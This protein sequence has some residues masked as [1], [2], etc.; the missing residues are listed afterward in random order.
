MFWKASCSLEEKVILINSEINLRMRYLTVRRLHTRRHHIALQS[1]ASQDRRLSDKNNRHKLS[2][3]VTCLRVT[4]HANGANLSSRSAVLPPIGQELEWFISSSL[5]LNVVRGTVTLGTF[6]QEKNAF[7]TLLQT[8]CEL[9]ERRS[10]PQLNDGHDW[11]QE[12]R[13]RER[14]VVGGCL[15]CAWARQLVRRTAWHNTKWTKDDELSRVDQLLDDA[16]RMRDE[17]HREAGGSLSH[18]PTSI[19]ND[20]WWITHTCL[21]R[22]LVACLPHAQPRRRLSGWFRMAV[23]KRNSSEAA[24]VGRSVWHNWMAAARS[25]G[26]RHPTKNMFESGRKRCCENGGMVPMCSILYGASVSPVIKNSSALLRK[27]STMAT[28]F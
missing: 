9:Y 20:V 11:C 2:G 19:R 12:G 27:P 15:V 6:V 7:E 22:T 8:W 28:L 16:I 23:G 21:L 4:W 3:A 5:C 26:N 17:H 25:I 14:G 10:G 24:S 18:L 13:R 1:R